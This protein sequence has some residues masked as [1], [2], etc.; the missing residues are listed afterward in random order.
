VHTPI[1]MSYDLINYLPN[2][3]GTCILWLASFML[4][5]R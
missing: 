5:R 3:S 1:Q 4:K 2:Q